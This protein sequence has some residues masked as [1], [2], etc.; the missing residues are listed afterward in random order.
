MFE[1]LELP[2]EKRR[3]FAHLIVEEADRMNAMVE[4]LLEF[5]RGAQ[6]PLYATPTTVKDLVDKVC[7]LME[8]ELQAKGIALR[9]LLGYAGPLTV[10]VDRMKRAVLNIASNALDAM[11]AGGTFTLESRLRDGSLELA[12][13][14]TGRGIPEELQPR[15][16]EPFFTHGKSHGIGLGMSI[17]RKIV[18]EHGGRIELVSRPGVGTTFTLI[19]PLSPAAGP[20]SVSAHVARAQ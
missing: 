11:D 14:D 20:A 7:R 13:A 9:R 12:L 6:T 18:E 16:F 5:T 10:D 8:P 17:T 3:E 2:T 1:E 15:I 19:L 4:E